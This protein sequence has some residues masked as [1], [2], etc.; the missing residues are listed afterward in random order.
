MQS[1]MNRLFLPFIFSC[2][3]V[4][5]VVA[6]KPTDSNSITDNQ[7]PE[8]GQVLSVFD[9]YKVVVPTYF[10]EMTDINPKAVVQYGFISKEA[11]E[12]S[13]LFDDEI[14]ITV[15]PLPK[16]DLVPTFADTNRVTLNKVNARTAVNL[17]AILT[18]FKMTDAKPK[19]TM[20]NGLAA[21]K[22]EFYGTLGGYKVYYKMAI[23]ETETD[24]YQLLT[25]CM[26][27]HA[28]KHKNEMDKMIHSFE[29]I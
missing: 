15:L 19:P 14:Y 26:Q 18:D 2:L 10:V 8:T 5:A 11:D 28:E 22:N 23:Y 12:N 21:I 17:E 3:V 1:L 4:L 29:S 13:D 20:I 9:E 16:A 6:C 7:V 27:K 25:W 24:F